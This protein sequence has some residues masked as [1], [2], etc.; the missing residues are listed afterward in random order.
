MNTEQDVK[1]VRYVVVV[2]GIGEQLKNST[3]VEMINRFAEVRDKEPTRS[4][5]NPLTLGMLST[6]T[7]DIHL[8]TGKPMP[9]IAFEGIPC[10]SGQTVGARFMGKRDV[11][12]DGENIRFVEISWADVMDKQFPAVG[13][14][15]GKWTSSLLERLHRHGQGPAWAVHLISVLRDAV[16]L[17]QKIMRLKYPSLAIKIFNDYLGDVQLYGEYG[18]CRGEGVRRFHDTMA[19]VQAA[20]NLEEDERGKAGKP[21][22]EARFTVIAHSLGTVMSMDAL[23]YACVQPGGN[24]PNR[25]RYAGYRRTLAEQDPLDSAWRW[26]RN[27]DALV[28]LGSPIDKYLTI[29]WNNYRHMVS[30][31]WLRPPTRNGATHK[32]RHFNYN[33]EQDPVGGELDI[34]RSTAAYRALFERDDD[35]VFTRYSVPGAAHNAYWKDLPLF[36]DIVDRAVDFP[37]WKKNRSQRLKLFVRSAYRKCL[38]INYLWLPLAFWLVSSYALTLGVF[39]DSAHTKGIAFLGFAAAMYLAGRAIQFIVEGRQIVILKLQDDHPDRRAAAKTLPLWGAAVTA[40]MV[41]CGIVAVLDLDLCLQF[42]RRLA[43]TAMHYIAIDL[44]ADFWRAVLIHAALGAAIVLYELYVYF[45]YKRK[46]RS[47]MYDNIE[48]YAAYLDATAAE[49]AA[50]ETLPLSSKISAGG[51]YVG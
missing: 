39:A 13:E 36:E 27:V 16:L 6:Q 34:V 40:F 18:P 35:L 37:Q 28:T 31:A 50:R 10:S 22:R 41:A 45:H 23:L 5:G 20:H 2:H 3:L 24:H 7:S 48:D 26:V 33:D 47:L 4:K 21:R 12:D 42:R 17:V 25:P 44:G 51:A 46:F 19:Q 14:D 8:L 9:W 32:I 1:H 49:L 30:N 38:R 29:W 43:V 15:V 11:I